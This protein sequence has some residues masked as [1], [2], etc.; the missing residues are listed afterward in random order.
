MKPFIKKEKKLYKALARR[1]GKRN[2][3]LVYKEMAKSGKHPKNFGYL[4]KKLIEKG[5][6]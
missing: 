2:G 4:T 5:D 1:Y 3:G 6:E